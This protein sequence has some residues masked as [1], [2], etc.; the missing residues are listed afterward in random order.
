MRFTMPIYELTSVV[1]DRAPKKIIGHDHRPVGSGRSRSSCIQKD[2]L[3]LRNGKFSLSLGDCRRRWPARL[4]RDRRHVFA[5]GV[6][7][8][9]R[10]GYRLVGDR[11]V[12]RDDHRLSRDGLRQHDLGH[13]VRP[14]GAA[15]GGADRVGRAAGE[16][17]AGQPGDVAAR[18]SIHLRA[19]GRRLHCRDL[20]AHDGDRHRLVRH[21]SQ[22]CGVAGV[23]RHGHGADDHVAVRRLAGHKSSL[24]NL[25]ADR[26][27]RGGGDHD[28]GLAAGAPPACA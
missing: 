25:D 20:R 28:S 4:R 22:P 18:I 7:A 17:G 16:P 19:D 1:A 13:P 27:R 24:A 12:Q 21:A 9:D 6:P 23:C 3:E 14:A 11:R 26:G 10:A 5:A 8:A 2:A 15:A